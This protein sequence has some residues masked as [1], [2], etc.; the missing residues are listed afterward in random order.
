MGYYADR[1]MVDF[2]GLLQSDV[3]QALA[4]NDLFYAIPAYLPD[5]IVLGQSLAV[6][7]LWLGNDEWFGAAYV[8]VERFHDPRFWGSPLFV[9]RRTMPARTLSPRPAGFELLAGLELAEFALDRQQASP[10][11]VLQVR[12]EWMREET[13][14]APLHTIA[15]LVNDGEEVVHV[16]DVA[17]QPERWPLGEAVAVYYP[18]LIPDDLP[19]GEYRLRVR[20]LLEDQTD[21]I[22]ELASITI[23]P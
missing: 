20:A 14:T 7:N 15:Y 16:R 13:M 8:P 6:Y 4:R 2:L 1:P 21:A 12:M 5:Y 9:F 3:A 10:G 17:I 22:R 11:E 23:T 19:P 18:L